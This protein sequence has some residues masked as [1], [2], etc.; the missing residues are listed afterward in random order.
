MIANEMHDLS[1]RSKFHDARFQSPLFIDIMSRIVFE[2]QFVYR[3]MLWTVVVVVVVF[4]TM[5]GSFGGDISEII[6]DW[7]LRT[8]VIKAWDTVFADQQEAKQ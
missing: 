6:Q 3:K 7:L 1:T 2:I 4:L 5:I 8:F